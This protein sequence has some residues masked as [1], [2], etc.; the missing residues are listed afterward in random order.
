MK[1]KNLLICTLLFCCTLGIQPLNAQL[2]E[3]ASIT[4]N[5]AKFKMISPSSYLME[6]AGPNDYYF[7]QEIEFTNNISLSNEDMEGKKFPDGT[8]KMQVTPIVT[9]SETTRQELAVLRKENDPEKIAAYRLEHE[10][11][12]EV[13]V[14]NIAFSIRNGQF[15]TP[16]QK[17]VKGVNLPKTSMI[18]EQDLWEQDHPV[19]YAS[20]NNVDIE[21][22]KP[23][24]ASNALPLIRDNSP[25]I[26][27]DQQFLDD[28]IVV[29]SICVGQDC[30]NGENF[31]FDTGRYKE[32]NL[33]IHFDDTS[34]SASF[35][36]NDW[37]ITINDSSNG[38][39]SYFAVEDATAGNIPFRV[40]AGAGANA[41]HVDASGGNVGL[42]TA[43]PVVEL[44][45]VDGD[46]PTMRLEQNGSSGFTP[47]T[48]DLAGNETNF[49]VRDVTNGSLLP[50]RIRPSAPTNSIYVDTDGDVGM[51]TA[52]PSAE[53]HVRRT[54]GSAQFLVEEAGSTA[55]FR[56]LLVLDNSAGGGTAFQFNNASHSIDFNN[57]GAV[58]SEEFRINHVDGDSQEF[59]LDQ[60]GNVII[61][62]T[63]T[64]GGVTCGGGCDLVFQPS[65]YTVPSIEEHATF[66]WKN[67]FLKAVG[68]TPE[69][70]PMNVSEKVGGILNELEHAHIYIEQLNN[71]IKAQ[72][73]KIENL[74]AQI[75]K[76]ETLETQLAELSQLV[77]TL[78]K[79]HNSSDSSDKADGEKE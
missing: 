78:N 10:L 38:G 15:V 13:N 22:G 63:M 69:G 27:D 64:T 41:L 48:W 75:D 77:T 34:T 65:K 60:A 2:V 50:F 23:V 61:T 67:S 76:M 42:G 14:Y 51:G 56:Y 20:L 72:T 59:S 30:N 21:Y 7:R 1:V 55:G 73:E 9:L 44:H 32:N 31:G 18:W 17:E 4:A 74:E 35:P 49:F 24:V 39:S 40:E 6:I 43:T 28:V 71:K 16:D 46:S 47:Q 62:G 58:G 3:E 5:E 68:P 33:R 70:A 25:M 79:T 8:Y 53:L 57:T 66:M 12:A 11:P 36:S 45:V 19:L 29:G 54:D 52:S 37:R 26:E